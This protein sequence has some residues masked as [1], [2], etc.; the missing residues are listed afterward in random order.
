MSCHWDAA[1]V[2]GQLGHLRSYTDVLTQMHAVNVISNLTTTQS[3]PI[4]HT[5]TFTCGLA[6]NIKNV[7]SHCTHKH[8][9]VSAFLSYLEYALGNSERACLM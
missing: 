5:H 1:A 9:C 4:T 7:D 3:N 2:S 6:F 8:L